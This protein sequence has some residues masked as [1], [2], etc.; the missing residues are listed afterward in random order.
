[1]GPIHVRSLYP[2]APLLGWASIDALTRGLV[3]SSRRVLEIGYILPILTGL[4]PSL[5][6]LAGTSPQQ[7]AKPCAS[8]SLGASSPPNSLQ[9]FSAYLDGI[10][11]EYGAN[12]RLNLKPIF[13]DL[14]DALGNPLDIYKYLTVNCIQHTATVNVGPSLYITDD[15]RPNP[16]S[17]QGE[18]YTFVSPRQINILYN[19]YLVELHQRQ[20]SDRSSFPTESSQNMSSQLQHEQDSAIIRQQNNTELMDAHETTTPGATIENFTGNMETD[21]SSR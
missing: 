16:L 7:T 14:V 11:R 17:I 20:I 2:Q 15:L 18:G 12:G 1:M 6:A 4:P 5:K 13:P 8:H 19:L 21:V 10:S 9:I 3:R